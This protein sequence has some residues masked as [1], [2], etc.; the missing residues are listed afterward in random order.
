V[1]DSD[2]SSSDLEGKEQA[3]VVQSKRIRDFF[4]FGSFSLFVKNIAYIS[5]LE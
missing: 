4:I 3:T 1:V 2:I 5:A